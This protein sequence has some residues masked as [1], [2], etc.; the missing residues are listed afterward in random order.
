VFFFPAVA[1]AQHVYM[2]QGYDKLPRLQSILR[3]FAPGSR[4]IVFCSTKRM[5]DQLAGSL[6]SFGASAIHGDKKQQVRRGG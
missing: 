1:R 4:V 6:R 3:G 2:L 5:C